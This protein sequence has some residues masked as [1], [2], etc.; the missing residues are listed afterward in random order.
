MIHT[1]CRK[2]YEPNLL[3]KNLLLWFYVKTEVMYTVDSYFDF[4]LQMKPCIIWHMALLD[5]VY[6]PYD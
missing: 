3:G 2:I 1:E 6:G 4:S 5:T